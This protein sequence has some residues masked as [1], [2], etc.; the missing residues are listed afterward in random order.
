MAERTRSTDPTGEWL[1]YRVPESNPAMRLFCL[2]HAGGAASAFRGWK[3]EPPGAVEIC[4]VQLPGREGRFG[5]PPATGAAELAPG[6]AEALLPVLDRPF[7]LLGNS[8]GA[9][10]AFELARLLQES[11]GLSPVR[12]VVSGAH[13]PGALEELPPLSGL[14]DREFAQAMNER[15][16]GIPEEM[17]DN[18]HFLAAFLPVLRADMA[19][20]ENYRLTPGPEL[21][22]PITALAGE[23]DDN[24]DPETLAGWGQL[25]S[26]R[27]SAQRI[28]GGHFAVLD[29][30]ALVMRLLAGDAAPVSA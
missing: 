12:L 7:T 18:P 30:C 11:Y 17:I 6:L 1:P 24:L 22:C 28:S 21:A 5:E 2:P 27:F 10:I 19:L 4:A 20:V 23:E 9:L 13:P 16:G 14:P 15:H 3:S 26:G 8:M 25:T 29:H